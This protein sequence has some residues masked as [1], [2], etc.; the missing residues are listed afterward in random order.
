LNASIELFHVLNEPLAVEVIRRGRTGVRSRTDVAEGVQED[1]QRQLERLSRARHFA[2][3]EVR[4]STTWDFPTHE[5]IIRRALSSH[6]GLIVAAPQPRSLGARI[7]LTNT[8]WELMRHS[9]CPV[10]LV[11]SPRDYKKPA[12]IAALD[13]FHARAKPAGLDGVILSTASEI[14][15][16]L[17]GELHAFHAYLPLTGIA[18][19]PMGGPFVVSLPE[20]MEE[21]HVEQVSA[22]FAKAIRQAAI[23]ERRRHVRMGDVRVELETVVRE[24]RAAIVVMG[25]VSRSALRRVF[26]G[27]TAESM[28]DH[29]S[30]DLLVVKP[31]DFVT[32]VPKRTSK[33]L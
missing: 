14:A 29:L 24:T 21:V 16:A 25:A 3:L 6:A 19:S 12:V 28:L 17:G 13:P 5:A 8:D 32:R 7:F 11:K 22:A 27:S 4:T 31:R 26:I 23:P 15:G 10:L 1:A 30:C 9:P 18:P 33:A 20:S 2:G